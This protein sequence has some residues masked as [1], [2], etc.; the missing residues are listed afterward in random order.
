MTASS[1][2]FQTAISRLKPETT[3][4]IG[5]EVHGLGS[6]HLRNALTPHSG[7]RLG[8]SATPKRW[9]DDEGTDTIFSYFGKTCFEYSLDDAIGKYLTPY[10]YY[11]ELVNLSEY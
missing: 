6:E 10:R 7:M 8:L 9:Y 1:P 5:D 2:K 3:L 11:P 4:I